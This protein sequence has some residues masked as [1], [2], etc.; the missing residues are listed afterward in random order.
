MGY[1]MEEEHMLW[2]WADLDLNLTFDAQL[3]GRKA[4]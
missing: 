1:G 4:T 2:S 3:C